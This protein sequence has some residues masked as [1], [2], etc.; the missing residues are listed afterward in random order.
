MIS[1]VLIFILG[2]ICLIPTK[3][4]EDEGDDD[5][6]EYDEWLL[7][8]RRRSRHCYGHHEWIVNS[9]GLRQ[10]KKCEFQYQDEE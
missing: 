5:Y 1:V 3:S 7:S 8:Q 10:C 9:K 2:I 6:Q 4:E